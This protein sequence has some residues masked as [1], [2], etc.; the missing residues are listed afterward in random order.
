MTEAQQVLLMIQGV[1]F[2]LP[3]EDQKQVQAAAVE[4]RTLL[5]AR[6]EH[7]LMALGLVA[8]EIEAKD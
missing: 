4:L 8:A 1:I 5:A 3:E 7:G 2:G 6:K